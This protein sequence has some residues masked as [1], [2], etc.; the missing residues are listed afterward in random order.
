MNNRHNL[1]FNKYIVK[2]K[3]QL[4]ELHTVHSLIGAY[5]ITGDTNHVG[6]HRFFH[7]AQLLKHGLGK[8]M[9][10]DILDPNLCHNMI[11][12]GWDTANERPIL[13]HVVKDGLKI[14]ATCYFTYQDQDVDYMEVFIPK[15]P[16]LKL[17]VHHN[18]D[19]TAALSTLPSNRSRFSWGYL[20]SAVFNNPG[21]TSEE[22]FKQNIAATMA[23][24]FLNQP[25]RDNRKA[26]I[27]KFHCAQYGLLI[28]QVSMILQ[29]QNRETRLSYCKEHYSKDRNVVINTLINE[30]NDDSTPLGY[31]Y[32]NCKLNKINSTY[33]SPGDVSFVLSRLSEFHD[34]FFLEMELHHG[35]EQD[36]DNTTE[37]QKTRYGLSQ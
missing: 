10:K 2:S 24:L 13:A 16:T 15:D 23:D 3:E 28:V 31:A 35:H 5:I 29:S 32:S 36:T 9:N 12:I 17:E 1:V 19:Q 4:A 33:I 18:A 7:R 21:R 25:L 30:L 6:I 14:N 11:C 22:N 37:N 27:Q 26:K 20:L 34:L 8:D